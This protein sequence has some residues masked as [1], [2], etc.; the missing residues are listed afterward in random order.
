MLD[1]RGLS[2]VVM[3]DSRLG[4]SGNTILKRLGSASHARSTRLGLKTMPEPRALGLRPY[5]LGLSNISDSSLFGS[6]NMSNPC[7]PQ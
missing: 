7:L 1:L 2:L 4:S 6:E 5:H 3:L